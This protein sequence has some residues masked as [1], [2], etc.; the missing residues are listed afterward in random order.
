MAHPLALCS[1]VLYDK[2]ILD[3][4]SEIERLKREKN[5]A[6]ETLK[7]M[8]MKYKYLQLKDEMEFIE[9][10]VFR[11]LVHSGDLT[12]D[13]NYPPQNA[14]EILCDLCKCEV[15][16]VDDYSSIRNISKYPYRNCCNRNVHL[17]YTM[18]AHGCYDVYLGKKFW[19]ATCIDDQIIVYLLF[20]A[21]KKVYG[22]SNGWFDEATFFWVVEEFLMPYVNPEK[23]LMQ[24]V[25]S[26]EEFYRESEEFPLNV[27]SN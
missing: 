22:Y 8:K 19:K 3:D 17:A 5:V 9:H 24:G 21:M 18:D 6:E 13:R 11:D 26:F 20:Y 14:L 15:E 23:G 10:R 4:R 12:F 27:F 25:E 1:R 16:Y 7:T 2:Q